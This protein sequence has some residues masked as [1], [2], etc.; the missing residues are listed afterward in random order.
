MN[1]KN[2]ISWFEIPV[3]DVKRAAQFYGRILNAD[4]QVLEINNG[5]VGLL[6]DY[7]GVGGSLV[8]NAQFGYKPSQE[9]ALVYL[10]G[11]D[12]LSQV[13]NHVEA[14]GGQIVLPKTA[15]GDYGFAAYFIDTE[16]NKIGLRSI[17]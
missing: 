15:L 12:D 2:A 1:A 9:G 3:I 7:G 8:E 13:L 6:P 14:A 17:G 4:I 10:D 5:R 11:G 16:G